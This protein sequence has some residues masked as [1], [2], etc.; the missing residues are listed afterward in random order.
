[1]ANTPL[2]LWGALG[3]AVAVLVAADLFANRGETRDARRRAAR[4]SAIWIGAGAAFNLL[5]WLTLGAEP[6]REYL[7]AYALEESLSLDNLFV[8][9]VIFQTLGVPAGQQRR[10]LFWG[11]FGAIAFRALF[12]FLGTA[13]IER[14]SWLAFVFGA[15][16]LYAAYRAY[17]HDPAEKRASPLLGWLSRRLP[18]TA[19]PRGEQFVVEEAGRR[20]ATPLLVA[21]IAIEATDIVFAIDS[22]PAALSVTHDP[23]IIYSSNVFAILGLRA[24]YVLLAHWIVELKYLHYALA[25]IL[26]F[27]AFK[28]LARPWLHVP[29]LASVALVVILLAAAVAP[30]VA[31][32]RRRKQHS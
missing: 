2:W 20:K 23:F 24:L 17:A 30:R 26:G 11:I 6:A 16:L 13:A 1:M 22:I 7:A 10:V 21:L 3:G 29:P 31:S 19:E 25:G 4:W 27:A 9:L 32:W 18:V 15:T 8:F 28:L 5:V 12:I 14:W